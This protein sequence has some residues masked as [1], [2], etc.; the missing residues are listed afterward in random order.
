M[1]SDNLGFA[2]IAGIAGIAGFRT[3]YHTRGPLLN[4]KALNKGSSRV[5]RLN[6]T[7]KPGKPGKVGDG[8]LSGEGLFQFSVHQ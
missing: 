2:G 8:Q 7:G 6:K 5:E 4:H 1:N 3:S